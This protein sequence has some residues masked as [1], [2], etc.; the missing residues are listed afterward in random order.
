M[1]TVSATTPPGTRVMN[2]ALLRHAILIQVKDQAALVVYDNRPTEVAPAPIAVLTVVA[3]GPA[4]LRSYASGSQ[5]A[6]S[7]V[8]V[9]EQTYRSNAY[10]NTGL[11]EGN[12]PTLAS[13]VRSL[14][15]AMR[16][17]NWIIVSNAA[18]SLLAAY[19]R[20]VSGIRPT[21]AEH[22]IELATFTPLDPHQGVEPNTPKEH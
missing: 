11:L 14:H 16:K 12:L 5:S 20:L 17:E 1:A 19:N 7:F 13:N 10:H 9:D 22:A 15:V 18:A 2:T 3:E 21:S 4:P 6:P 8:S